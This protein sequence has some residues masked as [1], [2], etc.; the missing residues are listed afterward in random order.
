[1]LKTEIDKLIDALFLSEVDAIILEPQSVF[2]GGIIG[3]DG[4]HLIYGYHQLITAMTESGQFGDEEGSLDWF[5]YNTLGM[6]PNMGKNAPIIWDTFAEEMIY[7]DT[8]EQAEIECYLG[9]QNSLKQV[10]YKENG[11]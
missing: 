1:M 4:T 10:K 11:E 2:N 9:L 7:P 8:E 5:S 3:Y 6:L